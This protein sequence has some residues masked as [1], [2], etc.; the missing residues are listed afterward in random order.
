MNYKHLKQFTFFLLIFFSG[1]STTNAQTGGLLD[2][3][4]SPYVKLKNVNI[5]DVKWSGG[6]WGNR[7]TQAEQTMI[8]YMREIYM[9]R[10]L[11]NF[12]VAAGLEKGEFWGSYWHDG[13]FYKWLEALVISY[14]NIKS[15]ETE[16]HI[17]EIISVIAKAQDKDGYINTA[18][19]IGHGTLS[20]DFT[21]TKTYKDKKRW[22]S[23]KE[24]EVYNLGHLFTLAALHHRVTG[25]TSLLTIAQKAADNLYTV[26]K[27]PSKQLAD[28]IFN[29][30]QIMGLIELYRSTGNKKYLELANIFL[31]MKGRSSTKKFQSQD[32]LP[33][34]EAKEAVGH[35]VTGL[36]LYSGMADVYAETGDT[37]LLNTL[38][39]L[40]Q[41][42]TSK[43]M[44][45]TGA[46]GSY[47]HGLLGYEEFKGVHEAFGAE[48]DLPNA[49]AYNETCANIGN[50]MWNW[51]ML[52]LTGEAKYA[53]VM[54]QVFYNSLLS[55]I[56]LEG[57]SYYYTN[58]LRSYGKDHNLLSSDA[59]Q[60]FNLPRGGVCCPPNTV[61]TIAEMNNYA[62]NISDKGIWVNLYGSNTLKTKLLNGSAISFK[63]E[64]NYPWEENVKFTYLESQTNDF[65]LSLRIPGWAAGTTLK[66]NGKSLQQPVTADGYI[67]LNRKWIKGDVVEL[68]LPMKVQLVEANPL[69]EENTNKIVVKRGP[70]VYCLESPD[71][72]Q[73]VNLESISIPLNIALTPIYK[74]D[75]LGGVTVLKGKALSIENKTDWNTSL[76]QEAKASPSKPVDIQLI[77]YYSWSNR[78]VSEMAVWLPFSR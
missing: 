34:R 42:A 10:A 38:Q 12:K 64:T 20:S 66:V 45:I 70:I 59:R 1:C 29:P 47:H 40:W 11:K 54:E 41:D 37:A 25:K 73:N 15:K 72:P 51:R 49:T 31:D 56:G 2:T 8:P 78:G 77:P 63:Q 76:Y 7:V 57:K 21:N 58:V 24:H 53:D 50:G 36:Y 23:F 32:H 52:G 22:E 26:F 67:E 27:N 19:Q 35:A 13:D 46:M 55:A 14:G 74:N 17:D 65:A 4:N 39:S 71:L 44:Y 30:P 69:V 28:L 62:Y 48:Y 75:F 43:K 5:G 33:V 60:R 16:R 6:F 9:E 61:R 68:H 3:K 18:I